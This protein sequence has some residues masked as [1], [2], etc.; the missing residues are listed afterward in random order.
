MRFQNPLVSENYIRGILHLEHCSSQHSSRS[1]HDVH[2]LSLQ[3]LSISFPLLSVLK[4]ILRFLSHNS[5]MPLARS[6]YSPTTLLLI[7][8]IIA[9][10]NPFGVLRVKY[11]FLRKNYGTSVYRHFLL[12]PIW[13]FRVLFSEKMTAAQ[14]TWYAV[15]PRPHLAK[16]F[17]LDTSPF[18]LLKLKTFWWPGLVLA[19]PTIV[20][21]LNYCH[22]RATSHLWMV[23]KFEQR[24]QFEYWHSHSFC[25]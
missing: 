7:F 21:F 11:L 3:L 12:L 20:S 13:C 25:C 2:W 8:P 10:D 23:C 14:R 24:T 9:F 16:S 17:D 1:L 6:K 4:N 5:A 19:F 15:Q 18:F 22:R